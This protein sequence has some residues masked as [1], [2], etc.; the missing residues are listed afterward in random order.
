[1]WSATLSSKGQITLPKA[2]REAFG[3]MAGSRV[4]FEISGDS[5]TLRPAGSSVDDAFG[6]LH[7]PGQRTVSVQ[8]MDAAIRHRARGRR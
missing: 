8:D 3:L 7:K 2:L 6:I 4:T 5:A 1:M